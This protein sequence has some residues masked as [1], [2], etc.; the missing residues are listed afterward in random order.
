VKK[1]EELDNGV[2]VYQVTDEEVLKDNIYCERS[3]TTADSRAFIY[4]RLI[5][6][7]REKYFGYEEAE[8]VLCEFGTWKKT[9][10]GRGYSYLEM[11]YDGCLFFYYRRTDSGTRELVCVDTGTPSSRIIPVDGDVHPY[12]SMAVNCTG[13]L[14][15]YGRPLSFDNQNFGVEIIDLNTGEK[16]V[17]LEDPW[18]CNPHPQFDPSDRTSLLIQQN[19]GCKFAVNGTR[20]KG[21]GKEGATLFIV[22]A[23]TGNRTPLSIGKPHTLNCSGHEQWIGRT[24]EILLSLSVYTNPSDVPF[25][26]LM[27]VRAGSPAR[28]VHE[29]LRACHVHASLCGRYFLVDVELSNKLVLGRIDTG[30]HV[31]LC[32]LGSFRLMDAQFLKFDKQYNQSAHPHAYL[33]RDLKW[34]IFNSCRTGRPEIHVASIPQELYDKIG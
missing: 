25:P 11:T 19:R 13:D 20:I 7:D 31:E 18:I 30:R 1:T 28:L 16:K 33:S 32:S 15:A 3:Y 5:A 14:I 12:S 8:Y 22:N 17:I 6:R 10:L 29:K 24:S 4:Q 21:A 9:I 2:I 27:T 34:A 26:T 23:E